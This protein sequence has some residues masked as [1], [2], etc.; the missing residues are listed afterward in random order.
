MELGVVK[1][2]TRPKKLHDTPNN[3]GDYEKMKQWL[4]SSEKLL[5]LSTNVKQAF[6]SKD[7]KTMKK[8]EKE[9]SVYKQYVDGQM[10]LINMYQ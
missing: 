5:K 4:T 9:L 6:E 7:K 2:I 8:V 3:V 1:N 10:N